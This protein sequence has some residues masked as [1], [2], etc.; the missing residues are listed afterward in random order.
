MEME[1]TE[2]KVG[3]EGIM[4]CGVEKRKVGMSPIKGSLKQELSNFMWN[5]FRTLPRMST[6]FSLA[7]LYLQCCKIF[8]VVLCTQLAIV[9]LLKRFMHKCGDINVGKPT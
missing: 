4:D 1:I 8:E 3:K 9:K 6:P 7:L 2:G 5:A